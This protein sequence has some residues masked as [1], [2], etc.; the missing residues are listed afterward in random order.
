M[1][2]ANITSASYWF[3]VRFTVMLFWT[4]RCTVLTSWRNNSVAARS[5]NPPVKFSPF[6]YQMSITN[7]CATWQWRICCNGPPRCIVINN[8]PTVNFNRSL[9]LF[10]FV[11]SVIADLHS[12]SPQIK[13][14]AG[15]GTIKKTAQCR[16]IDV[17]IIPQIAQECNRRI[18]CYFVGARRWRDWLTPTLQNRLRRPA[19]FRLFAAVRT[20]LSG[21]NPETF[22]TQK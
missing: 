6:F 1:L 18:S 8:M 10:Q 4:A 11:Q 16:P 7:G 15:R 5:V 20:L 21:S 22:L 17:D 19:L 14:P 12:Q 3:C 9:H 2:Y 13:N